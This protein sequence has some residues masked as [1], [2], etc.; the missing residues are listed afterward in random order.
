MGAPWVSHGVSTGLV[1]D[2]SAPMALQ[3]APIGMPSV[4]RVRRVF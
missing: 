1:V 4:Y 3:W 2:N